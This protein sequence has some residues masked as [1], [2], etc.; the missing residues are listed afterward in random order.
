MVELL[1]Q[2]FKII[3]IL[4]VNWKKNLDRFERSL[5]FCHLEFYKKEMPDF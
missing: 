2:T 1:F 5:Q 3:V 4:P